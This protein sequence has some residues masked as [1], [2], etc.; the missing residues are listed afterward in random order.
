MTSGLCGRAVH[1]WF[2]IALA[3][4]FLAGLAPS[5]PAN[6]QSPPLLRVHV[7]V[8]EQVSRTGI[9]RAHV[10]LVSDMLVF[11]GFTDREGAVTLDRIPPGQ[12]GVLVTADGYG[13]PDQRTLTATADASLVITAVRTR[14]PRIGQVQSRSSP[15]PNIARSVRES[16][17]AA[18]IAGSVGAALTNVPAVSA[19]TAD[20]SFLIHNHD[21]STTATTLNGAPI[22][23]SGTRNQLTL[24]NSD[25]F[26][27]GGLS[28]DGVA[29]A[30]DAALALNGYDPTIDWS[31]IIQER[32][33]SYGGAALSARERG[34]AGRIGIAAIHSAAE[35]GNQL[36][37]LYYADTSGSAYYHQ[38]N[39]RT[40]GDTLT[41]RYGFDVNHIAYLDWGRLTAI[42]PLVCTYRFGPL[43]CG[44]GRSNETRS[45]LS[46]FQFRDAL[47]LD[48]LSID[49]MAFESDGDNAVD[50]GHELSGGR[51][52]G[53]TASTRS[54]R[55]GGI[56]KLGFLLG[57]S[58]VAN[59]SLTSY[60]DTNRF[61]GSMFTADAV[62]PPA[63]LS[64]SS[65]RFDVPAYSA[66]RV[67]VVAGFGQSKAA[68]SSRVTVD[69]N[70][71]YVLS[72]RDSLT[73][74]YKSGNLGSPQGS[75]NGI[76][77]PQELSYDCDGGRALGNGPTFAAATAGATSQFRAGISHT[78]SR[79]SL[80]VQ[81]FRDVDQNAT[82]S[83]VVPAVSL[84]SSFFSPSYLAAADQAAL[85]NCR[86]PFHLS[87]ASLFYNVTAPAARTITD[88]FDASAQ[89]DIG[90]RAHV[91]VGY[92]L[93]RARAFGLPTQLL[94]GYDL[95]TGGQLPHRPLHRAN[96]MLRYAVSRNT[97]LLLDFNYSGSGNSFRAQPLAIVDSG[98]RFKATGG[99]FTI[100]LQN[101]FNA[102]GAP[103]GMFGSFP[104]VSLPASPRTLSV[105][106][107][108]AVGRQDI[109]RVAFASPK[110]S[111]SGGFAL[112]A[113]PFEPVARQ[114]W[115]APATQ[116]PTCGAE[117]LPAARTYLDRIRAFDM[118][119]RDG[120]AV[121]G[122][123]PAVLEESFDG[124]T[125]RRVGAG[126][127]YGLQ[128]VL[129]PAK[130]RTLAP[131]TRCADVHTGSYED[132]RRLGLY[133][134]GWQERETEPNS[135]YY[136]PQAGFYQ[137]PPVKNGTRVGSAPTRRLPARAPI[138]PFVIDGTTC[139]ATYIPAVTDA[140][141]ALRD[142]VTVFYA[143]RR[144]KAPD[145]FTI[146]SHVAKAE[147]WL[148]LRTDDASFVAAIA[149]CTNA[150]TADLAEL[151]R[152]GISG[153]ALPDLNYAPSV[154][155]YRVNF[156]VTK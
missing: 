100:G 128:I 68:G 46:F 148:D 77:A 59:L 135:L 116:S 80:D 95:T 73:A 29:G 98:V 103:F 31:G 15:L 151:T 42:Q 108:L 62:A 71:S 65:I 156:V 102:D 55:R 109:D 2:G 123:G 26:S 138:D 7:T 25:I 51:N 110:I 136:A 78:G 1:L 145:G 5:G 53:F 125:I 75:F 70:A 115:F 9:P 149:V 141:G 67:K 22:F 49:V 87:P 48:R 32:P 105:R 113:S 120:M 30:P 140:L 130:R 27:A 112:F 57:Q 50:F 74:S 139:P 64:V 6:G 44:Y 21:A 34:T 72:N 20:G 10:R 150:P 111:A 12:Y 41:V 97:T 3:V 33:S 52:V 143:G 124:M 13:F 99:D 86:E 94:A 153:A 24:L 58:R 134:P 88:G 40:G 45:S 101:V 144:P 121:G 37:G 107:R 63:A 23:P 85:A 79:F 91:D 81:A 61:S 89:V 137:P 104:Q 133:L 60:S 147:T 35:L 36:D 11:D 131:F 146:T 38:A 28:T 19:S 43:P 132:A 17:T 66:N 18:Q 96:A 56:V 83:A 76:A 14:P 16:D 84:P 155:L 127:N 54:S 90:S 142:Y 4:L 152:R 106:Y 39:R 119:V 93:A 154:G 129:D 8:R 47:T 117:A 82:I 126:S 122:V 69:A 118:R 92:S 114:D